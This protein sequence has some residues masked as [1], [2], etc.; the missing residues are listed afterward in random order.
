MDALSSEISSF[1]FCIFKSFQSKIYFKKMVK[2]I[3]YCYISVILT[4]F[5]SGHFFLVNGNRLDIDDAI[6]S[7]NV[8]SVFRKQPSSKFL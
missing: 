2:I 7:I 4:G 1:K 6:R 5:I 8:D 3:I